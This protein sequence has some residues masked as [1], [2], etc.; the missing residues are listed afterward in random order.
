MQIKKSLSHE[1][2]KL[3]DLVN[4]VYVYMLTR[5]IYMTSITVIIIKRSGFAVK[6]LYNYEEKKIYKHAEV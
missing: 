1:E 6:R 4:Y 2:K 5:H 3:S